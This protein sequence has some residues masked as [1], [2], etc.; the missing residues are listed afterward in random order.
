[1]YVA[2]FVCLWGRGGVTWCH[3]CQRT[4]MR[5]ERLWHVMSC[6]RAF[7][8]VCVCVCDPHPHPVP[9]SRLPTPVGT[10]GYTRVPVCV[11]DGF[12][13]VL[14]GLL[15]CAG[16]EVPVAMHD[17]VTGPG[18]SLKPPYLFSGINL[19]PWSAVRW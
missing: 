19:E 14:A 3:V 8:C 17:I 5:Y 12:E 16:G 15:I 9:T 10:W 18:R 6:A 11:P 1:M 2:V 4:R 13:C 7:V